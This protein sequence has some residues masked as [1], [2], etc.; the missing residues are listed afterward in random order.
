MYNPAGAAA[1]LVNTTISNNTATSGGGIYT[2]GA[3]TLTSSTMAENAAPNASAI[4]DP[5]NA[6]A[7]PRLIS[8]TVIV[9]DCTGAS[10][11]SGGYNVESP[12]NTCGLEQSTDLTSQTEVGLGP[13]QDNGGP[14]MTHALEPGSVGVDR[15]PEPDCVDAEGMPL[16][17]DQ[18][19]APRPAGAGA[20]CDVGAY[21]A[22][23]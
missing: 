21:E 9:G 18:R 6:N 15:I 5:E 13:L 3:L 20:A 22:Q 17:T 19:G 1:E 11:V 7:M 2:G 12:G 4:F 14:T 23:L 16:S 8:S 10:V